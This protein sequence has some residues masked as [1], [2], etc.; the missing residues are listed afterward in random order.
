MPSCSQ[1]NA[2][3]E[4]ENPMPA[5]VVVG[6]L[7]FFLM[8]C[9]SGLSIFVAVGIFVYTMASFGNSG[10]TMCSQCSQAA[11]IE[12]P[13]PELAPVQSYSNRIQTKVVGVTKRNSDGSSRQQI[14]ASL[15][16]GVQ[17]YLL[18]ETQNPH[19]P[20]AVAVYAY[21]GS[22]QLGY[23]NRKVA[24]T[25]GPLLDNGKIISVKV[26][27]ITGGGGL[28]YGCNIAIG[29]SPS[30]I[31]SSPARSENRPPYSDDNVDPSEDAVDAADVAQAQEYYYLSGDDEYEDWKPS[32]DYWD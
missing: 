26:T 4:L 7:G 30:H 12:R 32:E 27:S 10:P 2:S 15:T 3:V 17:V 13:V 21:G 19:D 6:L 18:R 28:N 20:N 5:M 22:R 24:Q 14:V 1:C 8:P 9:T 29:L 23:L 11:T 25:V 16:A 31:E